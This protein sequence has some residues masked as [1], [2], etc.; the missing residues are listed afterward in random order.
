ML[1]KKEVLSSQPLTETEGADGWTHS[2]AGKMS[3]SKEKTTSGKGSIRLSFS[4][5][6]PEKEPLVLLP[7]LTMQLME[8]AVS[9]ITSMVGTG[10]STTESTFLS[11]LIATAHRVVNMNLT[12]Q[13]TVPHPN[14]VIISP[15][16]PIS[17]IWYQAMEPLLS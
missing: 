10:K 15:A 16:V 1:L 11:I 17:S 2:G 13:T 3:F 12:L 14:K 7:I 9:P 8:I 6:I 5:L 4:L